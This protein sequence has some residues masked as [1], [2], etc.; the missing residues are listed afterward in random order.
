MSDCAAALGKMQLVNAWTSMSFFPLKW[1][2]MTP[3]VAYTKEQSDPV[4]S[5]VGVM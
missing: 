2:H 3:A 5:T 1:H 4:G